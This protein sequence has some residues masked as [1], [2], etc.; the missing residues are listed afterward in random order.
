MNR[1]Y[2]HSHPS[3][4]PCTRT[5]HTRTRPYRCPRIVHLS[6]YSCNRWYPI[7]LRNRC[8]C[9]R[10]SHCHRRTCRTR[11]SRYS[12]SGSNYFPLCINNILCNNLILGKS[13]IVKIRSFSIFKFI[14]NTK[15]ITFVFLA[16]PPPPPFSKYF[17]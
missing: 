13:L 17:I 16:P 14:L 2:P 4:A 15:H 12:C 11:A 10:S 7:L 6:S 3:S 1:G 5:C 9:R 8:S